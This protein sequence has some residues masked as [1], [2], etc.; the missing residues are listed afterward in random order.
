M[1]PILHAPGVITPGQLGPIRRLW[2]RRSRQARALSIS[3]TGIPS[4]IQT[5]TPMPASAASMIASAAAW[6]GAMIMLA[7]APVARTAS[8]T[9]LNT[10]RPRCVSPPLPGVTPP[11]TWVW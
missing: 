8:W 7:F 3:S 9:L 1:I 5:M 6:A 11:T 4:V 10:G 2:G